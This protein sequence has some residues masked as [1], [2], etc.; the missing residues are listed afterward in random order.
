MGIPYWLFPIGQAESVVTFCCADPYTEPQGP[1][2]GGGPKRLYKAP[3]DFIKPQQTIQDIKR[4]HKDNKRLYKAP[5]RL[6]KAPR[7]TMR[8]HKKIDETFNILDKDIKYSTRVATKMN[9]TYNIGYL[10]FNRTY[11]N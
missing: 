9:L 10:M 3:T 6:Y 8:R 1:R 5:E 7:Q 4:L 2:G 11:T